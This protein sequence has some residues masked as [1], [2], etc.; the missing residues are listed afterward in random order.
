MLS[1]LGRF[2]A[3]FSGK[4]RGARRLWRLPQPR[5]PNTWRTEAARLGLWTKLCPAA[6][7]AWAQRGPR[8]A[9]PACAKEKPECATGLNP[10]AGTRQAPTRSLILRIPACQTLC[11]KFEVQ[12]YPTIKLFFPEA[13]CLQGTLGRKARSMEPGVM[14]ATPVPIPVAAIGFQQ[15]HRAAMGMCAFA[16]QEDGASSPGPGTGRGRAQPGE[17]SAQVPT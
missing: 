1:F 11:Q 7:A 16:G 12:G 9:K 3:N 8:L 6:F 2:P 4:R 17:L 13:G 14:F 5:Q 10:E 15:I